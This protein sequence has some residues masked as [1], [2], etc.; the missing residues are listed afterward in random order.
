GAAVAGGRVYLM[1]RQRA[2]DPAGKPLR[3][4]RQGILGNER[5]LCF[6][7]R[8]GKLLWKHEYDCPYTIYYPSGPRVT[9]VVRDGRVYTLGAMGHLFCFDA[10]S[11][12][13]I[14]SKELMKDYKLDSPPVWRFAAHPLL[15]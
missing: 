15:D 8:D 14:W 1:D 7:A 6:D 5:V 11:G 10:K 12:K 2:L 3:P 9:P 4:T 13:P